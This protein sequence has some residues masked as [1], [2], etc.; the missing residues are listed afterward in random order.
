M[1]K[2]R[3]APIKHNKTNSS[4]G[5]SLRLSGFG[6]AENRSE[7]CCIGAPIQ[8]RRDDFQKRSL[9]QFAAFRNF[10]LL[11]FERFRLFCFW[12]LS[13]FVAFRFWHW[14]YLKLDFLRHFEV[15]ILNP[16]VGEAV[17]ELLQPLPSG[18]NSTGTKWASEMPK[19]PQ[20]FQMQ[21][22]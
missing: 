10:G 12:M 13:V 8:G 9:S 18:G 6:E 15:E 3:D 7:T 20:R 21:R 4:D 5:I 17:W 22:A 2:R 11:L 1:H 16:P 19:I 14:N